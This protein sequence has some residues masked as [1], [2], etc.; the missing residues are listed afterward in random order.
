MPAASGD[1]GAARR[2][3]QDGSS[4]PAG[5]QSQGTGQDQGQQGS[6][7]QTQVLANVNTL[8]QAVACINATQPAE[9]TTH[10]AKGGVTPDQAS[11]QV[12]RRHPVEA[13]QGCGLGLP[14]GGWGSL[15][16]ACKTT[17]T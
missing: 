14:A 15:P 3:L 16:A 6:G 9:G 2:L 17:S 8:G 12:E 10:G 5:D 13:L 1:G 11:V 4:P 7:P